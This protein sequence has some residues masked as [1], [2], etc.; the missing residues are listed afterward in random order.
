MAGRISSIM[1]KNDIEGELAESMQSYKTETVD[2]QALQRTTSV[3][4]EPD[5]TVPPHSRFSRS[6]KT[7]L[8]AQCAFTGFFSTI[9]GAIYYP[10]LSVIEGE[11]DIDEQLVNITVVVYFVFQGLAP[12]FM[13]GFA[14]SLGR[15]PVVLAAIII[16]FGACIGL[17]CA[18]TYA[19]IIVLRCLQAA[20]ISPVIAIN[21]GIMGDITTRA[22]R[23]GYVG[24]AAGFQ[25]LG[26]AF[27]ALIGAG[28][29]FRWGWRAI[30]WFLAIGSGIC[31]LASF[32]ILPETKRNI[33][34]NGSVTP[35][36]YLNRAPIL[37]LS[38]VRKSLRLDNPDYDTLEQPNRFNLLAPFEILRAY[39][40]CILML[41]AGLQFAMYTTHLTA[42][43]TAL[44]KEYHLSVAKVG[45]CYLPSGICT[46]CSIIIAGRYLNWN[47]RGRLKNYQ[48]WLDKKRSKLL[49]EH[50]NDPVIVQ[51]IIDND[52]Q[53]TFNIFKARLQPA[54]VTLILSSSGFC[55]Y[56]WC[57]TVKAPLAAVL[58]MSGFASLFSNCILAFSTTLIVDLFPT[59]TS[60]AT[61][62]LNLFRCILSAVLIAALSKMVEKMKYGGVFTFLG[63]LTSSSSILLFILLKQGKELTFKRKRQ[64]LEVKQEAKL[65]ETKENASSDHFTTDEEQLV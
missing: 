25:V 47:Y 48:N 38:T 6:F 59:N 21:S 58:C 56:G 2:K 52:P 63:A 60:T 9:A 65:L 44:S 14:D 20:G 30:F 46:L 64:E 61:G 17:A 36:S 12:T 26:S 43:S 50:E 49:E 13:G 10:V 55:A 16:Y 8:I 24:Y 53:Y 15:R 4:P 22:E 7:V 39:E 5:I 51:T 42:L 45:L 40:I 41:V 37:A 31:F 29:S 33:S 3:K 23:G 62:C 54:F 57:I 32:L 27:G 19:Q 18:Q 1:L 28:L 11:F 35:R 34:G